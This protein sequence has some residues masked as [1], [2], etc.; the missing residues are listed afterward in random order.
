MSCSRHL[1][2]D[3]RF[4]TNTMLD[5]SPPPPHCPGPTSRHP[6]FLREGPPIARGKSS[7]F[8]GI[9][10]S[11][12]TDDASLRRRA[13]SPLLLDLCSVN[14]ATFTFPSPLLSRPLL[15]QQGPV[16]ALTRSFF[17]P[18]RRSPARAGS[19]FLLFSLF[20]NSDATAFRPFAVGTPPRRRPRSHEEATPY[21][22]HALIF[23][24]FPYAPNSRDPSSRS[25]LGG[26]FPCP[27]P[28]IWLFWFFPD[29]PLQTHFLGTG[30]LF[31]FRSELRN[32][33][34]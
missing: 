9:L 13:N 20:S 1:T 5:L 29:F 34:L 28:L 24:S 14:L 2:Y 19:F 4:E 23:F 17:F 32:T 25:F 18:R 30:R 27:F 22:S 33:S 31:H 21:D 8:M 10:A 26:F 6:L 3:P 15:P 16:T 7:F 11:P 12:R